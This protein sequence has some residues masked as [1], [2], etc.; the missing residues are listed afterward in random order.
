M[1]Y[2]IEY[3][4]GKDVKSVSVISSRN[5]RQL[6]EIIESGNVKMLIFELEDGKDNTIALRAESINVIYQLK[7]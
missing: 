3:M 7:V 5:I 1:E 4:S 2:I 6:V